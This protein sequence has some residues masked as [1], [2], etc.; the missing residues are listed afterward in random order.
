[1]TKDYVL[2]VFQVASDS[3]HHFSWVT[4]IDA[5]D[6]NNSDQQWQT[7][8]LAQQD[9]AWAFIKNAKTNSPSKVFHESYTFAD[10]QFDMDVISDKAFV[11]T[12]CGFPRS[13]A[14][15][16]S[17]MPM[18][19][20]SCT[21]TNAVF[22]AVY[23]CGQHCGKPAR[24]DFNDAPMGMLEVRLNIDGKEYRHKVPALKLITK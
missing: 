20:L 23:R 9:G 18:R 15:D 8:K 12:K 21:D 11:V 7:Q 6:S 1:V 14:A 5:N 3:Q 13:D 19:M 24:I 22:I 17:Y 10:K 16:T 4:H 2:D